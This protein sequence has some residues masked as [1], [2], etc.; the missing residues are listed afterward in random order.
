M[1]GQVS[2]EYLDQQQGESPT[3]M[4]SGGI[5][6]N[7]MLAAGHEKRPPFWGEREFSCSNHYY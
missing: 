2:I 1:C 7:K 4:L 5:T 6:F 3:W